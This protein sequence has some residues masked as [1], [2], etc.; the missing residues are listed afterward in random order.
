MDFV[1]IK[2]KYLGEQIQNVAPLIELCSLDGLYTDSELGPKLNIWGK[3][4]VISA[5]VQNTI[6]AQSV[7]KTLQVQ[8]CAI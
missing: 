5:S 1:L 2:L 6:L 8:L 4:F 7:L 3:Q